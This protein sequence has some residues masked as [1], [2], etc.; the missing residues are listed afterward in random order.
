M[1]LTPEWRT[2]RPGLTW[3]PQKPPL[4]FRSWFLYVRCKLCCWGYLRFLYTFKLCCFVAV[5]LL[6]CGGWGTVRYPEAF[7]SQTVPQVGEWHTPL[8][9]HTH[10]QRHLRAHLPVFLVFLSS[11]R[12]FLPSP[13]QASEVF[14][15]GSSG[16][17]TLAFRQLQEAMGTSVQLQDQSGVSSPA[18]WPPLARGWASTGSQAS[19]VCGCFSKASWATG[20]TLFLPESARPLQKLTFS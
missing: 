19:L 15:P 11:L 6:F 17:C 7:T 5:D 8:P 13:C 16:S 12:F 18:V 2:S 4:S 14:R 3:V 9:T 20:V 10:E 1:L